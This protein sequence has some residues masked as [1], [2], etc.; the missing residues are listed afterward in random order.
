MGHCGPCEG[1]AEALAAAVGGC[2][3]TTSDVAAGGAGPGGVTLCEL[4][5]LFMS[6]LTCH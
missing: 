3:M 4:T 1:A 5:L 2:A 6:V